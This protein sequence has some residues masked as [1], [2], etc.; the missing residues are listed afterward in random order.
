VSFFIACFICRSTFWSEVLGAV[1]LLILM[2]AVL[3]MTVLERRIIGVVQHRFGPLFWFTSGILQPLADGVKAVL[4][5]TV[6]LL[7]FEVFFIVL[8][9]L[10]IVFMSTI[11][12]VV[13]FLGEILF[14]SSSM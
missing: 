5:S 1:F 7:E 6:L 2:V 9:V 4:K 11:L 10:F 3:G 13:F 12:F 8:P 14:P